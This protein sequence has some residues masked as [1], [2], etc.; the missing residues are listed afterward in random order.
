[1]TK[2][3][4]QVLSLLIA[5][6]LY[7]C[8]NSLNEGD[9]NEPKGKVSFE[10]NFASSQFMSR[11]TATK[12]TAIPETSWKNISSL[13]FLLYNEAGVI[14]YAHTTSQLPN[15]TVDGTKTFT[16]TDVPVGEYTL[17]VV[18]NVGNADKIVTTINGKDELWNSFNVRQKNVSDL[19]LNYKESTFPTFTGDKLKAKK[20]FVEPSEIFIG[21][22]PS[23][24]VV[25]SGE[26]A[27]VPAIKIA[28]EVSLM[29]LRLNVKDT[30]A[31][32]VN[33][34]KEKGVDFSKNAS[35]MIHRLPENFSVEAGKKKGGVNKTSDVD[36]ILVMTGN[37]IFK[38]EDP[39]TG[40][41]PNKILSGNF[42]MWNDIVV[43]PNNDGR[44]D[45]NSNMQAKNE[46]IYFV[47]ISGE[48]KVGHQLSD[49][50]SLDAPKTVYWSGL[51]KEK[52]LANQIREVNLTLKS[53]GT[54]EVPTTPREE[55]GLIIELGDPLPW[56]SEILQSDIIL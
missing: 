39:K 31:G 47:V 30:E 13:Q 25:K 52:F 37:E 20:A 12:S 16:Y 41:K 36:K 56:N 50:T 51:V 3:L 6:T 23:K 34:N 32:V 8:S 18:A 54:I 14:K 28:R 21:E 49:G 44:E 33:E 7:S 17:V 27:K 10:V 48:G 5:L 55:G 35:V 2:K 42:S 43:F 4:T 40:Y 53:G 24:V 9:I 38:T 22:A 19:L 26:V 46:R 1:M 11:A 15:G 29:R 45:D